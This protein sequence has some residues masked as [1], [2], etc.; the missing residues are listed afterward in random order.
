M[1]M[2]SILGGVI[3]M[4]SIA[5]GGGYSHDSTD[6]WHL[7]NIRDAVTLTAA[8]TATTSTKYTVFFDQKM[9]HPGYGPHNSCTERLK[10]ANPYYTEDCPNLDRKDGNTLWPLGDPG[11][12]GG[13]GGDISSGS[14]SSV[15]TTM[16]TMRD[17]G[18]RHGCEPAL[19]TWNKPFICA[20]L[21]YSHEQYGVTIVPETIWNAAQEQEGAVWKSIGGNN[22]RAM[23]HITAFDMYKDV[24]NKQ[25]GDV[26]EV[27]SGPWTQSRFLLKTLPEV[28]STIKSFTVYEP[29]ANFYIANV[30][31]CAYKNGKTLEAAD[32]KRHFDF[33]LHIIGTGGESLLTHPKQYD[34][35]VSI[36]VIE[37][38]QNAYSYLTGLHAAL[39]PGG[40]LIFHDRYFDDP[41]EGN[42]VL[43]VNHYHPIRITRLVL[44]L[45]LEHFDE[46]YRNTQP[47]PR[48]I[49]TGCNEKPIYFIGYKK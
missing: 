12:G 29:G 32:G 48:M 43:G 15:D 10:V 23:E 6:Y 39:K 41:N 25:L 17:V 47:T 2:G 13:G 11:D 38:V 42:C 27:G 31:T 35:L 4:S 36:N 3:V 8:E 20:Y 26:I 30:R 7:L 28:E 1:L 19:D 16:L 37:H 22:D 44:D 21:C 9:C 14:D 5:I 49:R 34:T 33:P 45:F 46:I 18:G 24:A 40:L